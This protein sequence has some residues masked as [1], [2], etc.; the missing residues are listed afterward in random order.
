VEGD[1]RRAAVSTLR[2]EAVRST[3][4]HMT[5]YKLVRH[6]GGEQEVTADHHTLVGEMRTFW[7]DA[8]EATK[9]HEVAEADL[10]RLEIVE[11]DS[12]PST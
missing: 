4:K 3:L 1:A 7:V 11:D 2:C 9:A 6:D 10:A 8:D 5:T 12:A